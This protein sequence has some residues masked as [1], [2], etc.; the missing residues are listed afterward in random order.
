[1]ISATGQFGSI[2]GPGTDTLDLAGAH[3]SGM[4]TGA[5]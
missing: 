3:G 5:S 2:T 1:V 4:Y